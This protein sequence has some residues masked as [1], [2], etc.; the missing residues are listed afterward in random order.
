MTVARFSE[1]ARRLPP[2]VDGLEIVS[3]LLAEN[4]LLFLHRVCGGSHSRPWDAEAITAT[5]AWCSLHV[6]EGDEVLARRLY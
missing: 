5:G 3:E 6:P 4:R 1:I 2:G